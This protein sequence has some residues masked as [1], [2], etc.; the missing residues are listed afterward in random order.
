MALEC[1]NCA[2]CP[3]RPYWEQR[4]H[5]RPVDFEH[6]GSDILILGDAPS[7]QD[8]AAGRPFTDGHGIAVMQR[9]EELGR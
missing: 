4:G 2:E 9:F 8:V 7:K 5:W 1:A 6:N 3:L